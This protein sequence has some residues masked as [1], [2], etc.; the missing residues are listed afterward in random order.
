MA[1]L[2]EVN[3][4]INGVILVGLFIIVAIAIASVFG[5]VKLH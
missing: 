2:L 5:Y 1:I 4:A 3:A